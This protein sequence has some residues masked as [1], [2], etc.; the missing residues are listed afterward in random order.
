MDSSVDN[1][2]PLEDFLKTESRFSAARAVN[3]NFD[4]LVENAKINN[5]YKDELKK[6]IAQ[7]AMNANNQIKENGEG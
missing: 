7:F 2:M 6:Y 5:R 4:K 1:L 3:P